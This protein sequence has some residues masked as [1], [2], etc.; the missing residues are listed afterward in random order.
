ME[1]GG[2]TG[3]GEGETR[4]SALDWRSGARCG[5]S[6]PSALCLAP[7]LVTG[8]SLEC[9]VCEQSQVL[10]CRSSWAWSDRLYLEM[11]VK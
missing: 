3:W 4:G 2:C 8:N 5:V 6:G 7:A 1:N 10:A 11:L 9:P